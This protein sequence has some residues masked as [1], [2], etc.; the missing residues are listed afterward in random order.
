MQTNEHYLKAIAFGLIPVFLIL[1]FVLPKTGS[2]AILLGI[3][4][5]TGF[6]ACFIGISMHKQEA[7]EHEDLLA[8]PPKKRA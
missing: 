8:L 1:S 2:T 3:V 4:M 5:I 7:K 6:V